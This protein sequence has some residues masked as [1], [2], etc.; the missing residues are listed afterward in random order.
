MRTKSVSH[1]YYERV[2]VIFVEPGSIQTGINRTFRI[3]NKSFGNQPPKGQ[4]KLYISNFSN[5]IDLILRKCTTLKIYSF[6]KKLI[7]I[8]HKLIRKN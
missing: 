7:I 2:R 6:L 5:K 3:L 8:M 1:A 4:T